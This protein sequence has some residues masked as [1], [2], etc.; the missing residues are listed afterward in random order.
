MVICTFERPA[1]LARCLDA[2]LRQQTA[3]PFEIIVVDNH[4]QSATT[5]ALVPDFPAVRW[6]EEP[7]AGLAR[8]RNLGIQAARGTVIVTTD[9]DV[10]APPEWL[11]QLTAPL[12]AAAAAAGPA[13]RLAATTGNCLPVKTETEAERLFEAYGGLRHGDRPAAFDAAW[14]AQWRVG[15]P[16]LWRIGTT[17]NA[18]FLA[19]ALRDPRVR[20]TESGPGPFETLLGAG[21]PAGA[22][23]DLYCFYRILQAGYSVAYLPEALVHHAHREQLPALTRQLCAYRRGETAFLTLALLRH[24]DLRALGQALLWIPFWRLRLLLGE[25]LRRLTGRCL[26]RLRIFWKESLAYLTGPWSL[27][28]ARRLSSQQEPKQ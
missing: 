26:F 27:W 2:L 19:C 6:L 28:T 17:A 8:A 7:V 9:D 13:N 11:Q 4:P 3:H 25:L 1:A 10:L 15:F 16:H 14:M 23:E 18:A 20:P 24:R 22:W 12:F 5:Q 21:T